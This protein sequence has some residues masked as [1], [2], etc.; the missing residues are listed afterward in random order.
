MC[1]LQIHHKKFHIQMA[2][3]LKKKKK[4]SA[5]DFISVHVPM[6]TCTHTYIH[7]VAVC[8]LKFTE[9]RKYDPCNFYHEDSNRICL[10][11]CLFFCCCLFACKRSFCRNAANQA[12]SWKMLPS[13]SIFRVQI[14][15]PPVQ[16][17]NVLPPLTIKNNRKVQG[18]RKCLC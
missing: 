4:F 3:L 9:K 18:Y 6:N 16:S 12:S 10:F 15:S 11:V 14:P 1:I 5:R 13:D 8:I 2:Q 17:P 7:S